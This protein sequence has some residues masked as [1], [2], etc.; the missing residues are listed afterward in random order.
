MGAGCDSA[1]RPPN[2]RWGSPLDQLLAA[3]EPDIGFD[4]DGRSA[5]IGRDENATEVDIAGLSLEPDPDPRAG[6][7]AAE[8]KVACDADEAYLAGHDDRL[9]RDEGTGGG[10]SRGGGGDP[11]PRR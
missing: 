3:E 2:R 4:D 5:D 9:A 11:L 8:D 7:L 6:R 1:R 10:A